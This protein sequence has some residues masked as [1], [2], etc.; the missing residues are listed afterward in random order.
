MRRWT[1]IILLSAGATLGYGLG[2]R[3][4]H[5]HRGARQSFERHVA[6]VCT[7]A[8]ERQHRPPATTPIE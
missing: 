8:Y 3:A 7:E 2:F 6:D 4:M 1:R 5:E